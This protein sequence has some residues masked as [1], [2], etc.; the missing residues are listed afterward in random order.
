MFIPRHPVVE[1]QFCSYGHQTGT[2]TAGIGGVVCYAGSVVYLDDDANNED[3]IVFQYTDWAV[4][5][6]T[7]LSDPEKIPFGFAMQKVKTGYHQVH[8]AGFSMPGDLGSSDVIAQPTYS[9]GGAVTGTKSAPL[10]VA[11]L[12]I[13]DTVHYVC[14][15]ASGVITNYM[16]PGEELFVGVC[17]LDT[18]AAVIPST[19]GRVTNSVTTANNADDDGQRLNNVVV[20]RVV[21]GASKVKCE[22]NL[23]NTTLY[24]IR[25]K[26]LI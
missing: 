5:Y 19:G 8:P 24:P 23:A 14:E 3:A 10:G 13:W 6:D 11:H 18:L 9:A 15:H 17:A 20:G 21:K 7:E 16:K 25:I 26:L 2:S 12:G 4:N 22:A 1:N